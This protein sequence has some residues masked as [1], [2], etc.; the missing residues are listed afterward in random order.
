MPPRHPVGGLQ[1]WQQN[2][3][4]PP[5]LLLSVWV[6]THMPLHRTVPPSHGLTHWLLVQLSPCG[7]QTP[8]QNVSPKPQLWWQT[9]LTQGSPKQ[10]FPHC[11]Q[12]C[13]SDRVLTQKP[14]QN[15]WPAAQGLVQTSAW[16]ASP[17]GQQTGGQ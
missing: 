14:P 5:Q 10:S 12:L 17:E 7:Q 1:N 16:Q 8:L 4:Q 3:L 15:S 11:P 6:L 13:E 9:A 2:M